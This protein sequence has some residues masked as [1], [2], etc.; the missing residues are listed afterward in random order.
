[1]KRLSSVPVLLATIVSVG[2]PCSGRAQVDAG[3]GL[4]L[5]PPIPSWTAVLD[6]SVDLHRSATARTSQ[7]G[8]GT[9]PPAVWGGRVRA[10]ESAPLFATDDL[11]NPIT[12]EEI[13]AR[14][15]SAGYRPFIGGL[16]GAVVGG[17]VGLGLAS[18]ICPFE[19]F[20]PS[21]SPRD[22]AMSAVAGIGGFVWGI[23]LGA[24]AGKNS[25]EIDKWE[26]LEL[27]REERR[28]EDAR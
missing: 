3:E 18:S 20:G 19:V 28:T 27:I 23:A 8:L 7:P 1:M 25:G 4:W 2:W 13:S 17:A 5:P 11:G 6:P 15:R 21:C 9:R 16:I 26:A 22:E 12:A 10:Q 24:I 14:M